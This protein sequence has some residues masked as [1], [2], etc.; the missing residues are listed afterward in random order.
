M[1][2]LVEV[3]DHV[4]IINLRNRV[5]VNKVPIDIVMKGLGGELCNAA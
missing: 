2:A 1:E 5:T 3:V 4:P